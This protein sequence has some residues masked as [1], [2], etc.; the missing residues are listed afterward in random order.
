[1]IVTCLPMAALADNVPQGRWTEYAADTFAGG[2]GTKDD[3]YQIGTAEQLALLVKDVNAG[4]KTH[5]G[6]YFIL[7]DDIDLSGHVWTPLGYETYASGG[8]SAQ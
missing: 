8:G 7:T 5:T 3:P 2:N 6:E 4:S 1:M